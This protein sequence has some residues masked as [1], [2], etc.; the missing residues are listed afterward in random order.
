MDLDV[1]RFGSLIRRRGR[2]GV[3]VLHSTLG[4]AAS[5]Q[6]GPV[7]KTGTGNHWRIAIGSVQ[8]DL[9]DLDDGL[10]LGQLGLQE[11]VEFLRR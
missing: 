9:A 5:R 7:P 2:H 11:A 1:Q 8:R 3:V 6:S 4:V 10:P